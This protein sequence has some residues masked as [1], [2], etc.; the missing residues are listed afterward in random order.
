MTDPAAHRGHAAAEHRADGPPPV[1]HRAD[2]GRPAPGREPER[3]VAAYPDGREARHAVD[4]LQTVGFHD[5]DVHLDDD[6]D[7]LVLVDG[8]RQI[9]EAGDTVAAMSGGLTTRSQTRGALIGA[10]IGGAVGFVLS[11][12]FWLIPID[13]AG[14]LRIVACAA[15]GTI[16]C[17]TIGFVY[18]GARLPQRRGEHTDTPVGTTVSADVHTDAEA[19]LARSILTEQARRRAEA[20]AAEGTVPP[21]PSSGRATVPRR[22]A[23]SID[24]PGTGTGRG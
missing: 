23:T 20:R 10:V 16:A 17:S 18:D 12:P 8:D 21:D 2:H 13:V 6:G 22:P 19:A 5:G 3:I 14:W 15:V 24:E 1:G 4:Q 9:D 7:R 11:I